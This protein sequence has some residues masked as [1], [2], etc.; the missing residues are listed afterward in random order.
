M[1]LAANPMTAFPPQDYRAP[2][3]GWFRGIKAHLTQLPQQ[4]I[5]LGE[6]RLQ[7]LPP[8]ELD[9]APPSSLPSMNFN[10]FTTPFHFFGKDDKK[11]EEKPKERREF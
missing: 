11:P 2:W 8:K 9:Q 6:I 5:L 1:G 10:L 3:L 7:K 4:L